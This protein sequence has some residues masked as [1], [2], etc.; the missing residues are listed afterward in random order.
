MTRG[1]PHLIKSQPIPVANRDAWDRMMYLLCKKMRA[2]NSREMN[3][4]NTE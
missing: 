4:W 2:T 1:E 3:R